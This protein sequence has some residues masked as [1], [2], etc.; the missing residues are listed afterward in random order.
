VTKIKKNVKT[1]YIYDLDGC[2]CVGQLN[3]LGRDD[4]DLY[5]SVDVRVSYRTRVYSDVQP[6]ITRAH[7]VDVFYRYDGQP[8]V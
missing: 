8:P 5:S 4:A 1:F 3:S 6:D 2:A 7:A